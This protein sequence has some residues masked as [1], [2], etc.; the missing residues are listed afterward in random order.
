MEEELGEVEPGG[1][2]KPGGALVGPLQEGLVSPYSAPYTPDGHVVHPP[3]S[4][5][6]PLEPPQVPRGHSTGATALGRQYPPRGHKTGGVVELGQKC[7]EKQG[8]Q[9]LLL[10]APGVLNQVPAGHTPQK[11]GC[12]SSTYPP[13]LRFSE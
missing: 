12:S 9:A 5:E 4:E 7:P 6:A 3:R 2:K 8:T 11:G 13:P 10:L 1:L